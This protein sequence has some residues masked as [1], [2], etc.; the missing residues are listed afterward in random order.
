MFL[1]FELDVYYQLILTFAA[2]ITIYYLMFKNLASYKYI[3]YF[4]LK[5]NGVTNFFVLMNNVYVNAQEYFCKLNYLKDGK[6][7]NGE[8]CI[9]DGNRYD[10]LL[11]IISAAGYGESTGII[12]TYY[13]LKNHFFL[14]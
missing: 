11:F 8:R 12:H 2:S 3:L 13:F 9:R 14:F 5:I 10:L 4:V 7:R 1:V 6:S